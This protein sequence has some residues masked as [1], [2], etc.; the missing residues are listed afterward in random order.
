MLYKVIFYHQGNPVCM[1]LQKASM[2]DDAALMAEFRFM[3]LF[4]N[5]SYDDV[6]AFESEG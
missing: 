6:R 5:V 4:P 3:A 1:T 2:P